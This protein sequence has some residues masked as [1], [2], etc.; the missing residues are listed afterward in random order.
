MK[1]Y[2]SLE[3]KSLKIVDKSFHPKLAPLWLY[4]SP[5]PPATSFAH[6]YRVQ[7]YR[8]TQADRVSY[9]LNK[10]I[11]TL[12]TYITITPKENHPLIP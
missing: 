7:D 2:K 11:Y 8:Q 5:D 1:V 6:V 3:T 12:Y 4:A 9:Q 10:H